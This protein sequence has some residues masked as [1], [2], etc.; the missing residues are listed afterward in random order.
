MDLFN[1]DTGIAKTY[2]ILYSKNEYPVVAVTDTFFIKGDKDFNPYFG[3]EIMPEINDND[4]YLVKLTK[5]EDEYKTTSERRAYVIG[6]STVN[7]HI[8]GTKKNYN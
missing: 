8:L 3:S 1:A 2:G 5:W 6:F 7:K 4:T